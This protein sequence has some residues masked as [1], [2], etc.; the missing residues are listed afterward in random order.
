M[1]ALDLSWLPNLFSGAVVAVFTLGVPAMA[2][3]IKKRRGEVKAPAAQ[4]AID[5][6][7]LKIDRDLIFD[8]LL[9]PKGF[10]GLRH[11]GF[12]ET[13]KQFKVDMRKGLPK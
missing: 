1:P 5:V 7:Q 4:Q 12:M 3:V 6:A 13:D 2:R 9:G 8:W 10:D 11:G